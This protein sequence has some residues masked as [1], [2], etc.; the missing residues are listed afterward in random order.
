MHH[1]N[2]FKMCYKHFKMCWQIRFKSLLS[3]GQINVFKTYSVNVLKTHLCF[4]K[5]IYKIFSKHICVCWV[6]TGEKTYCCS[7]CDKAFS[8]PYH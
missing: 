4:V 6:H 2:I 5:C 3:A 7:N 1:E 8:Q